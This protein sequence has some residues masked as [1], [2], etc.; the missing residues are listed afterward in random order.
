M[1]VI[2]RPVTENDIPQVLDIINYEILNSVSIYDYEPR[3]LDQQRAIIQEKQTKE[4]PFLVAV[5]DDIVAGFAT[6]GD[7]RFKEGYRF[8]VEHSVYL[9]HE[10]QGK[11]LGKILLE[12]LIKIAK[13]Q[14]KHTMIAVIDA[15]NAGSI[16]FHQR[17]GFEI[18]GTLRESGYKFDRWLDSVFLQ[19]FL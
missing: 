19:L 8:T 3:T 12:S 13:E 7:F 2:V 1:S 16:Q 17:M 5:Y 9:H 15:E 10:H 11:G 18:A 4:F 6:Y 14:Q